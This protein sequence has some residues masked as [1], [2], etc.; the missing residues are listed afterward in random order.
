MREGDKIER[1][2]REGKKIE[3]SVREGEKTAQRQALHDDIMH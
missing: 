3:K 1:S 2:L